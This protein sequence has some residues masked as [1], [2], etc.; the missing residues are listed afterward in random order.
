[1]RFEIKHFTNHGLLKAGSLVRFFFL[2]GE[3]R[4]VV[5]IWETRCLMNMYGDE[6]EYGYEKFDED[7]YKLLK[8]YIFL[9]KIDLNEARRKY[10][11]S[12]FNKPNLMRGTHFIAYSLSEKK[13]VF[14]NASGTLVET[15]QR[16][17]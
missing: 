17:Q 2:Y 10:K 4:E 12:N 15:P 8:M 14:C 11:N 1:M 9:E 3:C 5:E 16:K 7:S 13:K 6:L